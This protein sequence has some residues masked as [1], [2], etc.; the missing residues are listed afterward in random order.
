M[1]LASTRAL[2]TK[3]DEIWRRSREG[4]EAQ[5][6]NTTEPVTRYILSTDA[7]LQDPAPG[8]TRSYHGL[9][10]QEVPR[11]AATT[12]LAKEEEWKSRLASIGQ[13]NPQRVWVFG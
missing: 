10:G 3:V 9:L 6:R 2:A 5:L 4:V 7:S 1:T 13:E 12:F 8:L 11:H